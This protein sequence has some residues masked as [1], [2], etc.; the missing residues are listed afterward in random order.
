M[1][2]T[3]TRKKIIVQHYNKLLLDIKKVYVTE[4]LLP[5]LEDFDICEILFFFKFNSDQFH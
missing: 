2:Q 3:T 4:A 1:N 5:N